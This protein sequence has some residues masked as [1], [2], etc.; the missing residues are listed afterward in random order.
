MQVT[1]AAPEPNPPR[2][3]GIADV[4]GQHTTLR[5]YGPGDWTGTCPFCRSEAFHV[6]PGHGTFHCF[7]CG[8]GGDPESFAA[9]IEHRR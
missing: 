1:T 4:V 3:H 8:E 6:R 5:P 9:K 2:P 7:G